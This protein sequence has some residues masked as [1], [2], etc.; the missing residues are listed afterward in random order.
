[1]NKSS[2]RLKVAAPRAEH[3]EVS[4]VAEYLEQWLWGKQSL[5]ASTFQSYES[6]VRRYL[7]PHLGRLKLTSLRPEHV[8]RM[9]RN[10][11]TSSDRQVTVGTLR[12]I[13]STLMSALNTAVRR[14]HLER[15][16]AATVELPP[17]RRREPRTWTVEE[18]T[19]FINATRG[20]RLHVLFT[21]L[22]IVGLRRGEVL[23]L[24]WE[25]VDLNA[26]VIR[27]RQSAV[28]V[29]G[30]VVV[31][32]PKSRA[33]HRT[34]A[35]DDETARRLG[36]H[37]SQQRLEIMKAAVRIWTPGLVFTDERGE[38][39]DPA[40]V[41]RRFARLVAVHQL[42]RIRLHDLRHTSASLGLASGESLVEVS[43]RLGHSSLTV[44]ADIYS[45]ISPEVAKQSAERLA[46]TIYGR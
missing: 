26:G 1:M 11:S 5:R 37:Q 41:S 27:V 2:R 9:Y 42:P 12:R 30:R 6:H 38:A 24:R 39:L 22:A 20:D 40:Y 14:G 10:I 43:R 46:T 45:H 31:G 19:A 13:H 29:G 32:E 4:T 25:D 23:A 7:V 35:I 28:L 44:T 3:V 17:T 21:V 34:V 8:D 16:P 33:G 15:N 18:L 36:W